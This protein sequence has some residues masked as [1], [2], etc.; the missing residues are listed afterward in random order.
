MCLFALMYLQN[1]QKKGIKSNRICIQKVGLFNPAA[2]DDDD[3]N[4]FYN[5]VMW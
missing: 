1:I 3:D 2:A 4:V 5:P